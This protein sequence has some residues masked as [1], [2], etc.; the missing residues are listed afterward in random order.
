MST[1]MLAPPRRLVD[2]EIDGRAVR[3]PD[4]E[5]RTLGLPGSNEG[6]AFTRSHRE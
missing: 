3:V 1:V 6:P 5:V 2:L 4:D